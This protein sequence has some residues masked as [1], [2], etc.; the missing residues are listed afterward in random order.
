MKTN[1]TAFYELLDFR[2]RFKSYGYNIKRVNILE[3]LFQKQKTSQFFKDFEIENFYIFL[4]KREYYI[5]L[6]GKTCTSSTWNKKIEKELKK[7]LYTASENS[8]ENEYFQII[9]YTYNLDV[10]KPRR[11][12]SLGGALRRMF[13][14]IENNKNNFANKRIFEALEKRVIVGD[15]AQLDAQLYAVERKTKMFLST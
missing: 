4:F 12:R 14:I 9:D 11:L 13:S 6:C 10:D 3:N 1:F 8:F 7:I 15:K 2:S 5:V